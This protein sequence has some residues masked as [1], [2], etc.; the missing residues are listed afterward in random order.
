MH[1]HAHVN[2]HTHAR[3]RT[4]TLCELEDVLLAVDDLQRA[5]AHELRNVARVEE[6]VLV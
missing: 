2:T 1:M 6:T 3:N 5:A 4:R